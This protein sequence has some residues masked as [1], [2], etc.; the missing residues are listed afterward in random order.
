MTSEP[1]ANAVVP[2]LLYEATKRVFD[3]VI[4]AQALLVLHLIKLDANGPI[5]YRG[6]RI[7]RYGRPFR[8]YKFRTMVTEAEKRGGSSTADD[9]PRITRMGRFL[10]KTK[11]DEL[12]QLLNVL[13]GEMSLVGPRPQV[14]WAV[15]L[16]SERERMIL[17][18]RPGITDYASVRF[19]DEGQILRGSSNPDRDY[20]EKIHPEKMRLSLEYCRI[21]SFGT[22]LIILG[23][24]AAAV[25][26]TA[27][28]AIVN[29][30]RG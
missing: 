7:G 25:I 9:D 5:F 3:V 19:T 23:Q 10:R 12:P 28:L 16:Y 13:K 20:M 21:R 8:I 18:L 11:I 29:L 17:Q 1:P 4:S 22:D 24:T 26:K 2:P 6:D 30:A 15:D 27:A 14:K